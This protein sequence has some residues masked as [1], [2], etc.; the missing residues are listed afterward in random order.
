MRAQACPSGDLPEQV[1][2]FAQQREMIEPWLRRWGPI[3]TPLLWSHAM[4]LIAEGAA[5]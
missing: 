3:A 1:S 5:C 2:G 4:Y